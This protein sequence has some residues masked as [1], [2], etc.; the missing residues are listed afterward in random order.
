MGNGYTNDSWRDS[1][2]NYN[3]G[4][5]GGYLAGML[6]GMAVGLG[7]GLLFAPRAGSETR[8]TLARS[9]SGMRDRVSGAAQRASEQAQ[10][11]S[12]Q[13]SST[14]RDALDKGRDA[15]ERGRSAMQREDPA[16][17]SGMGGSVPDSSFEG[18]TY[19]AGSSATPGSTSTSYGTPSD[20]KPSGRKGSSG[21]GN[22]V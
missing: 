13:V 7:L 12:E 5:G 22:T 8:S 17:G 10:R 19:G 15:I 20:T 9:A 1:S 21:G 18:S 2:A 11:A 14:M 3:T 16:Y 6:A 4:E